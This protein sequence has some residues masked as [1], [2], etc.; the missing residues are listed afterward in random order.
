MMTPPYLRLADDLRGLF[1]GAIL[2]DEVSRTL[3]ATDA[4]LFELRPQSVA[5]PEDEADLQ[6]LLE[7]AHDHSIAIFPRGGGTGLAG[8][9]LGEGLVVDL[10]VHF[11]SILEVKS[12][13]VTVQPGVRL[14]QVNRELAKVGRRIA[15]D[16]GA[17]E[18]CTVGGMLATDAS[19]GNAAR[20]G[21]VGDYLTAAR[22][23]WDTGE[24]VRLQENDVLLHNAPR[25][26]EIMVALAELLRKSQSAIGA[27]RRDVPFDR[28]GYRLRNV[29]DG[30]GLHL[31]RI[32]PGSEGT[33]GLFSEATLRTI[34]LPGARAGAM[35]LFDDL[36]SA[37]RAADHL[38]QTTGSGSGSVPVMCDLLDRRLVSLIRTESA[39]AARIIPATTGSLLLLE[40]EGETP[41]EARSLVLPAIE[42]IQKKMRLS[43]TV[44]PALDTEEAGRLRAVREAVLPALYS[45]RRGARPLA[46]IEDVAVPPAALSDYL[47][48]V[49]TI[50]RENDASASFLVHALTGQVH[51]RPLLDIAG[52]EG[53]RRLWSIGHAVHSL[54]I[55]MGGTITSQ[56]GTGIARTPWVEKQTGDLWT[57]H[58]E[59]KRLFDP[60]NRLNPGKIIGPDPDRPA[61]PLRTAP[62]SSLPLPILKWEGTSPLEQVGACNGCGDCRS[63]A[64]GGRMCPT[65][66]VTHQ[67]AA[68]P[69]AKA[70]LLRR[71]LSGDPDRGESPVVPGDLARDDVRQVSDLCINCRMCETECPAHA[72][73]P[74][75]MLEVRAAHVRRHGLDRS[76]WMIAHIE[77]FAALGGNFAL[78]S[79]TLISSLPVRWGLEKLFGI[80]RRRHL[81]SFAMRNF[82]KMARRRGWTQ[83]KRRAAPSAGKIAYFIDIFAN[84]NDPSIAEAT[85]RVLEHHGYEVYVPDGQRGCGMAPLAVGDAET[86]REEI[87]H[88]LRIF[89]E[90]VRQGYTVVCSEP[91]A[92]LL[93]REDVPGL[94]DDA[95]AAL[96]ARNTRELTGL[97]WELYEAGDLKPGLLPL[98]IS[99]GHHVP[100]HMKALKTGVHGPDLLRLIPQMR[101]GTID[102]SCSGMAGTWGLKRRN[103]EM[104]MAAGKPMLDELARP[105]Y[106]FGSTEC[107]TCRMQM[108]QATNKRTLHPVQYLALSYG[109]L[110]EVADMLRQ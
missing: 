49:Q 36:S 26:L 95:D 60:L 83:K 39:E 2:R 37:L 69:R 75:L 57:V 15:V 101:V 74:R 98:D 90:L 11:R 100:C 80:S 42:Q 78:I 18:S 107:S 13:S 30:A 67:E 62:T 17:A 1:R 58:R 28:C 68:T 89:A 66:R 94:I 77:A 23:V 99:V 10:S 103:F 7:Y 53:G 59:V 3:Y 6:T 52:G 56:H 110:P 46:F 48:Q 21:T 108:E 82:L 105:A 97:L 43:T 63:L 64:P 40:Y 71:I 96:V 91:T 14:A 102:V 47:A 104:S 81:P 22:V 16:H 5:I 8:E 31:L 24:V 93:F 25:T 27:G 51:T 55:R 85:F 73:I 35:F 76:D 20:F 12:D 32:L 54:A 44:L 79:N 45:L 92:A 4:S 29:L 72:D 33:L 65:F 50:L 38:R 34:P 106:L 86:A 87:R 70:N 9:S 41:E 88:N 61:W 19:G 109:L 84:Y